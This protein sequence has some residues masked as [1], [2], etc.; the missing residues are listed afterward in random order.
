MVYY[1]IITIEPGIY[2]NPFTIYASLNDT[3]LSSYLNG[4]KMLDYVLK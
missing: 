1:N 2:F 3:K 4:P